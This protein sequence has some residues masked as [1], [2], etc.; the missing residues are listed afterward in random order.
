MIL[1]L[2]GFR[3]NA[4]AGIAIVGTV[5]GDGWRWRWSPPALPLG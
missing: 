1:V 3:G 4:E 5:H 2:W